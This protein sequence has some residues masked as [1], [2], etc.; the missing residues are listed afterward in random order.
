LREKDKPTTRFLLWMKAKWP[1]VTRY[2]HHMP[3]TQKMTERRWAACQVIQTLGPAAKATVPELIEVIE[4]KDPGDVNGGVMALWAVGIDADT[5]ERQDESLKQGK[6]GF[7]R[8][9]IINA[10]GNVKPPS[11]RTLN[12]II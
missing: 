12:A 7:G 4:S 10:L 11:A 3:D 6:A 2:Y 5:C 9:M 8:G 1:G